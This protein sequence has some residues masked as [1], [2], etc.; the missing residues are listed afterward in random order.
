[1][2]R[3]KK[4][5]YTKGV[6]L[7]LLVVLMASLLSAG[8]VCAEEIPGGA[9]RITIEGA[10]EKSE[11]ALEDI[12]SN[13]EVILFA[14]DAGTLQSNGTAQTD[15]VVL[16]YS[17]IIRYE[18]FYTR[19]FR[20][21]YDGKTKVAYCVQPKEMPPAEGTWTA[22]EYNSS[23]MAK[24][25]YY[26]Y[27]YPGYDK[28]LRP[29]LSKKD[30]DDDY[31]DDDGAYA[32]SHMILSYFY[33]KQSIS[34][35]AFLGVSSQTKKVVM[36]AAEL[37]ENSW[38]DVP[39]NSAL[40]LN[41]TK[42][43][44]VWDKAS[45]KQKTPVF[46]LNGHVDNRITVTV[47]DNVTMVRKSDGQEKSFSEGKKVKVFGGDSFYF[48][49]PDSV[50]GIYKSPEMSGVIADFQP[51]LISITGKQNIIFCGTGDTDSVSF[52]IEWVNFGKLNLVKLSELPDITG[53]NS[54][55]SLEWAEY[56]I[57]DSKGKIYDK[58]VTDK[59]GK[60]S[61]KL[62]YGSYY[63]KESG[64]PEGYAADISKHDVNIKSARTD[65]IVREKPMIG[66]PDIIVHKKD[67]ELSENENEKKN[68]NVSLY[69]ATLENAHY[70]IKYYDGYYNEDTD[71]SELKP[72]RSW[73]VRTDKAG[74]ASLN[75]ESL[76]SGDKLYVNTEGTAVLPLGTITIQETEAPAGYVIDSRV[77]VRQIKGDGRTQIVNAFEMLTHEE[78]IIRG[79]LKFLKKAE[80]EDGFLEGI[81]FR[82]TS[83]S[84]GESAVLYTDRNG[85]ASTE[86]SS[87]SIGACRTVS[88]SA[89][90]LPYD[91]YII[92]EERCEKNIGLQ[93]VKGIEVIVDKN[94]SV[95]DLGIIT[96][97]RI[98]L[99][100]SACE[101]NTGN[102][103][104]PAGSS[105][106]IRDTVRYDGLEIGKEYVLKGKLMDRS[107]GKI[108]MMN[109][110][111]VTGTATFTA[112]ASSGEECVEFK[113]DSS[114][115]KGK[116]L[117]VFEYLYESGELIAMHNDLDSRDQTVE[118]ESDRILLPETGDE[119]PIILLAGIIL[120][121][122]SGAMCA[123][124]RTR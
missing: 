12:N 99:H 46:K 19:N 82:I 76:V 84:T 111:D 110:H 123:L 11:Q 108:L 93:L 6:L 97:K 33:D 77:Y 95:V 69:A 115:L 42:A 62:P 94:N 25:L 120:T 71:F 105:V 34:S 51:Y 103:K 56:E 44:A 10:D 112:A 63:I 15:K 4:S 18:D 91:T 21:T 114:N 23:L 102:K 89:G 113:L 49:A 24:A 88:D 22:K 124:R 45:G 85:M 28:K 13:K 72:V 43:K 104:I 8:A 41:M 107:S 39:D 37:I 9:D 122:V 80:G 20:V 52:S 65:V 48:T 100:T 14:D 40:S 96:D 36:A 16:S 61:A 3:E 117:V 109:G 7:M 83:K 87:I 26:S 78:Q 66:I 31:E 64:A 106:T 50:S 5:F 86:K 81:P 90:A 29:Y 35:D 75:K 32:L 60:A 58:L 1:M 74:K 2:F 92:D 27:G 68:E 38:P 67:K 57:Y 121:A 54:N 73:V 70:T 17:R 79:D 53:G 119:F 118:V 47:P 55:Y 59:K 116:E 101:K 30:L 98:N